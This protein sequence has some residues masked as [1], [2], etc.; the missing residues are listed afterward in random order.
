[1]ERER[2]LIMGAAG[3]DFVTAD[4]RRVMVV[5]I[6]LNQWHTLVRATGIEEH[7]P[8]MERAF[9]ADFRKEE[10][11]YR[12]RDGIAALLKPWFEARTLDDVHA[13]RLASTDPAA[14]G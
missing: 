5:A 11:R 14:P 1:M 8:P 13:R 9:G 7:L 4:N 6:S 10:D 3:R 12:A 2:V